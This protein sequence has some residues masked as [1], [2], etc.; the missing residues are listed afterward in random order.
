MITPKEST[1][2]AALVAPSPGLPE[3][4]PRLPG[5]RVATRKTEHGASSASSDRGSATDALLRDLIKFFS[6]L[7]L[8]VVCLAFGIVL[9]FAGT[10]AQVDLGLYKAQNQ[11]F[12]S[13]FIYWSPTGGSL[14]IPVFPGGYLLGG[15]LLHNLVTAHLTRFKWTRKKAGLWLIHF[16]LI[17]LLLG[18]L[19][20][21]LLARE[22]GM[23]LFEGET[24][25]YSE[26]FRGTELALVDKSDPKNDLVY[27]IPESMYVHKT[28]VRDSRLPFSLRIKK[29]WP[30]AAVF[31]P[32]DEAPPMAVASGATAGNFKDL[33]VLAAP[34]SKDSEE[35][36]SPAALVEVLDGSRSLGTYLLSSQLRRGDELSAG[37]KPYEIALRFT[38]HYYPFSLTLLKATH[39][40]YRGTEIPKN[41]ASRVRL[42]RENEVRETDIHM[43]SPLRY[44]GL[45]FYQYQMAAD[46]M[47]QRAGEAPSSTLQVV[48]N[49]SWLTPYLSCILVALGLFIQFGLHLFG[50]VN[51]RSV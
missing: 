41:F 44:G 11:F 5:T 16:G 46:E 10:L 48:R 43:N 3:A 13:F 32:G 22:S 42:Q 34:A 8:T 2:S 25:N 38:R 6:S 14:R 39:E 47:V 27:S 28:E 24:K 30:N 29:F 26:A 37:G 18:Q 20:T 1:N 4:A 45:T 36:N 7:R 9:V 35:R 49:P 31:K 23:Q 17:L 12:R 15:V 51:K 21:D 50:F 33:L 19:L 40:K